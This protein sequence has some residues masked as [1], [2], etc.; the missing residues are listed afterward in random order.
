M[1]TKKGAIKRAPAKKVSVKRGSVKKAP[2]KK[3]PATKAAA[4]TAPGTI[5]DRQEAASAV[6]WE[7]K[8][9][10][11]FVARVV[12]G[13][14]KAADLLRVDAAQTSRWTS[15]A[16]VPAP[17]QARMLVDIEHALTHALLVWADEK[18]ARD[19]LGT[20]NAHLDAVAPIDWIRLHGTAEVVDAIRA[21]AAGAYA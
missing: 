11:R 13:T 5:A 8:Q 4:A 10:A 9:R 1:T 3:A 18:V 19:W 15:G 2:V 16:S 20:P 17:E 6:L 7:P 12:G 21:E 14:R